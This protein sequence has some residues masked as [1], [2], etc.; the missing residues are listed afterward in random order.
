[1]RIETVN[2]TVTKSPKVPLTCG[3]PLRN[4]TVDLLL[5]MTDRAVPQPQVRS[6]DQAEHEH[7]P[8]LAGPG[9]AL[10]STV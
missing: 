6:P 8:A 1:M 10:A 3:A 9:P 7:R 5:T 2:L 4:R